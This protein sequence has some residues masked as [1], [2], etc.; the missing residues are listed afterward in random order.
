MAMANDVDY[1]LAA[2]VWTSD[3]GR[4]MRMRK[5]LQ[6]G[7]V[8]VNDHIPIVSEM[9]HGGFKQSGY[10][11]D[12][13][14]LRRRA[15]HRGQARHDQALGD[16]LLD[17]SAAHSA[18]DRPEPPVRTSR[19]TASV[20]PPCT[21]RRPSWP[22]ALAAVLAGA[23]VQGSVG[24]GVNILAAPVL[25]LVEPDALPATLILVRHAPRLR[26]A[27]ARAPGH[28]PAGPALAAGRAASRAPPSAPCVVATLA[29]DALSVVI[30]ALVLV[31]VAM[32]VVAPPLRGH[33]D[34]RPRRGRRSPGRWGP[35]S[36]I[37]GPPRGAPLPAPPGPRAPLDDRAPSSWWGP[38]SRPGALAVAGEVTG[39]DVGLALV[40]TPAIAGGPSVLVATPCA[41]PAASTPAWLAATPPVL[42]RWPP[43]PASPPCADRRVL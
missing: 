42:A 29:A 15:L 31:A 22:V 4:A 26:H 43:W 37:G 40:L 1:G 35:P 25:A 5:A 21:S 9:P 20:P 2:S 23:F 27:R 11:K 41:A 34:Q 28:R 13:S 32:S 17:A 33:P 7:T 24:F 10:G 14:M 3:V 16:A 30:G 38:C 8:W 12:M 39:D 18:V 6:F 19:G 36:S